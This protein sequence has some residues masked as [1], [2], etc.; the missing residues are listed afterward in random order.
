MSAGSRKKHNN[1]HK[2]YQGGNQDHLEVEALLAGAG[3]GRDVEERLSAGVKAAEALES[4]TR[5][6]LKT[7]IDGVT[8]LPTNEQG[9]VNGDDLAKAGSEL[10]EA[11]KDV[12]GRPEAGPKPPAE[13]VFWT[14][15]DSPE[16]G[17]MG[18]VNAQE[19]TNV[20]R[21]ADSILKSEDVVFSNK[22]APALDLE[23]GSGPG[24]AP[25]IDPKQTGPARYKG[26]NL[27]AIVVRSVKESLFPQAFGE[28][29]RNIIELRPITITGLR[30]GF[31]KTAGTLRAEDSSATFGMPELYGRP[32]DHLMHKWMEVYNKCPS[33]DQRERMGVVEKQRAI[34]HEDVTIDVMFIEP[35]ETGM[36]VV[37]AWLGTNLYPDYYSGIDSFRDIR[38][39][40]RDDVKIVFRLE[41]K[42]T[43]GEHVDAQAQTL[44]NGIVVEAINPNVR[45]A[46]VQTIAKEITE[47]SK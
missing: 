25:E 4:A 18:G 21:I 27:I 7:A 46:F 19:G 11:L 23:A 13:G 26:K 38:R 8:N 22:L 47:G 35:D 33:I 30:T 14:R 43:R 9:M 12:A 1:S 17:V 10:N 41:G 42:Y 28:Q 29:L 44:L 15:R 45:S 34:Q 6:H 3:N 2:Q 20:G 36:K 32:I 24:Y 37:T 5:E 39:G 31:T 16:D 40:E